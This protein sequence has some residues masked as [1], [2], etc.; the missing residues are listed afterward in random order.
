VVFRVRGVPCSWRWENMYVVSSPKYSN[1][2]GCPYTQSQN[3]AFGQTSNEGRRNP[4]VLNSPV[5]P[6]TQ[7]CYCGKG[8]DWK[9][10]CHKR[11]SEEVVGNSHMSVRGKKFPCLAKDPNRLPEESRVIDSV[12]SQHLCLDQTQFGTYRKVS[13]DQIIT[14]AVSYSLVSQES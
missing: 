9:K 14:I 7:Y 1:R 5:P 13:Y 3:M 10:D 11:R 6:G 2:R 4:N 12:A 8:G